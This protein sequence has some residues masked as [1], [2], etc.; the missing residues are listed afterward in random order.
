M[1]KL[2]KLLK[3]N[4][5]EVYIPLMI[6]LFVLSVAMVVAVSVG[7]AMNNKMLMDQKLDEIA[8]VVASTG[9]IRGDRIT[10]LENELTTRFGGTVDYEGTFLDDDKVVGKVQLNDTV[11]IVYSNAEYVAFSL[12][13]W[14]VRSPINMRTMAV[15]DVYYKPI[16]G[17]V[18]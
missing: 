10:Q 16:S 18:D 12:G 5:G 11:Y 17:M 1:K 9:C 3:C 4:R 14:D 13:G 7:S 6:A 2:R 15:S 8:R